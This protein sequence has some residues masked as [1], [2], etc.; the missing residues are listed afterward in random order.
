MKCVVGHEHLDE[1]QDETI[2]T[3][4]NAYFILLS[5]KYK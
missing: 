2:T 1:N 5:T 4:M 3:Y